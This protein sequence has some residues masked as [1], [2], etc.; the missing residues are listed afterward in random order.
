MNNIWRLVCEL[1]RPFLSLRSLLL[2]NAYDLR[3]LFQSTDLPALETVV[4]RRTTIWNTPWPR[5]AAEQ[6]SNVKGL[7]LEDCLVSAELTLSDG[8]FLRCIPSATFLS[9][10]NT[11]GC[12]RILDALADDVDGAQTFPRL[13]CLEATI[14]E[15]GALLHFLRKRKIAGYPLKEVRLSREL[16]EK[17]GHDLLGSVGGLVRISAIDVAVPAASVA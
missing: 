11:E 6:L 14:D 17:M 3:Q 12:S 15:D 7:T 16:Q 4:M 13:E 2:T 1:T 8:H 5:S 9:L 10:R